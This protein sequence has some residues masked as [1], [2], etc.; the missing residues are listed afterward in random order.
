LRQQ[1]E[2]KLEEQLL[3]YDAEGGPL[4]AEF[5]VDGL[6]VSVIGRDDDGQGSVGASCGREYQ[7]E[8]EHADLAAKHI[9]AAAAQLPSQGGGIVVIDT[10]NATWLDEKDVEDACYG[11][12]GLRRAGTGTVTVRGGGVFRR[13][14]NTRISAVVAYSRNIVRSLHGH[15]VA[16]LHNPFAKVPLPEHLFAI[17]TCGMEESFRSAAASCTESTR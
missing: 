12:P 3:A 2:A 14:G 9:R 1:D 11:A 13:G 15:D 7:F 5:S 6:M 8:A 17:P 4:P 10:S 16:M